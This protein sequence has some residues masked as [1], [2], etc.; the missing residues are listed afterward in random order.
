MKMSD[1]RDF[2]TIAVSLR[3]ACEPR[4]EAHLGL[5]HLAFDLRLRDERGD[6][7]DDDDIH[8]S[9]ADQHLG[10]FQGLL[11]VVR[12]RDE[13]V[14]RVHAELLRVVGVERVLGVDE[15][16]QTA[17]L[18]RLR[19]DL[20]RERGLAGGLGPEDLDDPSARDSADT[21]RRVDRQR[22]GRNDRDGHVGTVAQAH[23][24]AFPELSLDLRQR[25]LDGA[26]FLVRFHAR[27]VMVPYLRDYRCALRLRWKRSHPPIPP[28][29]RGLAACA[30]RFA[31][32]LSR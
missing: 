28:Q 5:A 24:R 32:D 23:D 27:H 19:D 18:L 31:R 30:G 2:E 26:P 13:Q 15:T 21:E 11:A 17:G 29:P 7:V 4:L 3:R 6:R 10:D 12:L 20:E 8:R 1:V 9:G 14:V 25:R 16:G 22:T